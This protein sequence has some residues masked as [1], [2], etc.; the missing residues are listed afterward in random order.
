ME[1]NIYI[2]A[3]KRGQAADEWY[4][5]WDNEDDAIMYYHKYV[6]HEGENAAKLNLDYMFMYRFPVNTI[7]CEVDDCSKVKFGKT[8]PYRWKL[9]LKELDQKH[10]R[11]LR[12]RKLERIVK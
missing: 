5:I 2:M 6:H 11:I 12:E 4:G 8:S 7:F 9:K 1:N 3:C 10:D